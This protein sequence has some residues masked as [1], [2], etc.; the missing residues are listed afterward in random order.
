MHLKF[1]TQQT[2][3]IKSTQILLEFGLSHEK[4]DEK[5]EAFN[6]SYLF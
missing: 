1:N 4:F 6:L 3:L 2:I 5:F